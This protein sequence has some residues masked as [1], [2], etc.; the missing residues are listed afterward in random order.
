MRLDRNI[1]TCGAGAGVGV[2]Q[3]VLMKQ[4]VDAYGPIPVVGTYIPAPWNR[5]STLGNI[6]IGGAVFGISQ[7]TNVVKKDDVKDFLGVYGITAIVGGIMNGLFTP[8]VA[9]AG[10]GARVARAPIR[11]APTVARSAQMAP[12]ILTQTGIPPAK[13]LA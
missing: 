5:W 1:V 2:I 9:R 8:V 3:T 12:S 13:I 7:F 11:L 6:L 4:Y 10:A